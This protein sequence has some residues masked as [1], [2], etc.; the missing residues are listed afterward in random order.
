MTPQAHTEAILP[1]L[2]CSIECC[3]APGLDR[4]YTGGNLRSKISDIGELSVCADRAHEALRARSA[5]PHEKLCFI[6]GA[7]PY[8]V[9]ATVQFGAFPSTG[10]RSCTEEVN[11][12]WSQMSSPE[13][14]TYSTSY[15]FTS[16]TDALDTA[17]GFNLEPV[18][19]L[20]AQ[21][22]VQ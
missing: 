20:T 1:L 16:S 6:Y 18:Y 5:R 19:I 22:M 17:K 2:E 10:L 21:L 7:Q 14:L 8:T 11:M 13:F 9:I 12:T 3:P 15:R 4:R